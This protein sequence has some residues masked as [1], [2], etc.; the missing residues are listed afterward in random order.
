MGA[1]AKR[2]TEPC[3]GITSK[4]WTKYWTPHINDV[5]RK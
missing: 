5:N 1:K 4:K 2:I 3:H